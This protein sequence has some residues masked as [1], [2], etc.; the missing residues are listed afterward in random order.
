MRPVA[1]GIEHPDPMGLGPFCRLD[2]QDNSP[3]LPGVYAW[4]VDD[5]VMYVG[6]AKVLRQVVRGSRMQ[7]AYN[8]YTYIPPSKVLQGSSPRVR[9]NGLLNAALAK[10]GSVEWWWR[11]LGSE[12]DAFRLEAELIESWNPPWNLARPSSGQIQDQS[13]R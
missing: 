6:K 8:D 13:T 5:R 12:V 11:D 2:A 10:G 3:E 4:T 9:V 7:R 1:L